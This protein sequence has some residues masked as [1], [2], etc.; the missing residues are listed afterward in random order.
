MSRSRVRARFPR[1]DARLATY[2]RHNSHIPDNGWQTSVL[3]Q[4]TWTLSLKLS[5]ILGRDQHVSEMGLNILEAQYIYHV[6]IIKRPDWSS[7]SLHTCTKYLYI[8]TLIVSTSTYCTSLI[9]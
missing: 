1:P 3:S 7:L 6:S 9:T 8:Y 5:T 2:T 4:F